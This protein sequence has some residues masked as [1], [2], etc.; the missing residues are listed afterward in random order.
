VEESR[1]DRERRVGGL[2]L[3]GPALGVDGV[4]RR[5]GDLDE[6]LALAHGRHRR[7]LVELEHAGVPVRVVRPGLHGR[8]HLRRGRGGRGRG[9]GRGRRNAPAC[10]APRLRSPRDGGGPGSR[11]REDGELRGSLRRLRQEGRPR[12][13]GGGDRRGEERLHFVFLFFPRELLLGPE[14]EDERCCRCSFVLL[15]AA[16]AQLARVLLSVSGSREWR[17]ALGETNLVAASE[18]TCL[19]FAR[20][21]SL[22]LV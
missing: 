9:R 18:E 1:S 21:A 19:R 7:G 13:R 5:G 6:H 2:E 4:E 10:W 14:E 11:Q 16:D 12:V 8:G 20:A 22:G 3:A 17:G 15:A